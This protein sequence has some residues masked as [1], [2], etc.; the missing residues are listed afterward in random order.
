MQDLQGPLCL[1]TGT[2]QEGEMFSV[3]TNACHAR[4]FVLKYWHAAGGLEISR[5]AVI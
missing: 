1:N 5:Y 3:C 4:P 2:L